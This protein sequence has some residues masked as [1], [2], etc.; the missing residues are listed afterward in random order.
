MIIVFII[1]IVRF[2]KVT[3]KYIVTRLAYVLKD[4]YHNLDKELLRILSIRRERH[5]YNLFL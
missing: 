4:E 2:D 1:N 3:K 5:P